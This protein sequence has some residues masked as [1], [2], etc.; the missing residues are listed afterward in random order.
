ML[1]ERFACFNAFMSAS[2]IRAPVRFLP[3]S[4]AM[5]LATSSVCIDPSTSTT[6]VAC[7]LSI[8]AGI[9]WGLRGLPTEMSAFS[10]AGTVSSGT[11]SSD[12]PSTSS[13]FATGP[14]V[15]EPLAPVR[16]PTSSTL[17]TALSMAERS[18]SNSKPRLW[19]QSV[20][21]IRW[22]LDPKSSRISCLSRR[23]AQN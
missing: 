8:A 22:N 16:M 12:G 23:T 18:R 5:R 4:P 1:P 21:Q 13:G 2:R 19:N 17:Q 11:S 3:N 15:P 20:P 10:Y 6:F 9:S 14:S 7:T